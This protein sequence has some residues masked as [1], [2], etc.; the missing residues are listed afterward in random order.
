MPRN[1]DQEFKSEDLEFVIGGETFRM[2]YVR[3]E[4]LAAWEDDPDDLSAKDS[5][6]LM[7]KRIEL[8]LDQSN[9][10]KERWQALRERDDDPITATQMGELIT[11]MLEV[12]SAR[13]LQQPSS[14]DS[15]PG[16]TEA[17][18]KGE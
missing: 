15:G 14:S 5:L 12:Q 18:S 8:F 6:K 3:P 11:W 4:V 17:S 1:F 7:D 2:R 10:A 13:P 16:S 9:G